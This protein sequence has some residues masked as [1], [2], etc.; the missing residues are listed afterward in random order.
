MEHSASP[1]AP[2][3]DAMVASPSNENYPD[4][5]SVTERRNEIVDYIRYR[6][7]DDIVDVEL[8]PKHYDIAIRAAFDKYR[9]RAQNSVEESYCFL[10]LQKERQ[11]YILPREIIQVKQ[12]FRRGAGS[13]VGNQSTMF[14][15]FA[16]GYLNTYML[17]QGRVG[18]L[19][20]YEL[21]TGYQELVMRMFGGY[22][23]FAWNPT[24]K[25][26]T[27]IRKIVSEEEDVLLWTYNY[28]PDIVLMNDY[29]IMPW[30]KEYAYAHA[31]MMVGEAREKFASIAGPQGGSTLNGT[32]LKGEAQALM[33]SLIED[34]KNYVD[35]SQPLTWVQG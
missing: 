8:D 32:A 29:L 33:D 27:I 15:P 4:F 31:K 30:L 2:D 12:V 17:Q 28:K 34:L 24:S 18:G 21:Y 20:N 35:G 1:I 16:A 13:A 11:D 7:G 5:D 26:L 10:R 14:E 9:Q 25:R 19:V 23:N 22:L 6:L 3:Y